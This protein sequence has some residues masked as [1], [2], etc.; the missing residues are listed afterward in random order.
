[1]VNLQDVKI[2][3][4]VSVYSG[5]HAKC[6]CGCSGKHSYASAHR[7]FASQD[8][9]YEVTDEEV[10][11]REVTR[12]LRLIQANEESLNADDGPCIV[13]VTVGKRVYVAY[14]LG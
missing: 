13:S 8:R 14:L 9:G 2:S 11:N 10:N 3:D 12:V 7:A 5:K 6:C 4:V 1:M